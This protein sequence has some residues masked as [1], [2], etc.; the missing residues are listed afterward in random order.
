MSQC[1]VPEK[2][3][4]NK[5]LR[6]PALDTT[7]EVS[8]FVGLIVVAALGWAGQI[9]EL[10]LAGAILALVLVWGGARVHSVSTEGIKLNQ[11]APRCS[12]CGQSEEECGCDK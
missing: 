6:P 1:P 4:K 9:T 3:N 7:A 11:A 5:K 12:V 8:A 10:Y 2:P